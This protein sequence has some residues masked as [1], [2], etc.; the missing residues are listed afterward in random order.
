M[1][2]AASRTARLRLGASSSSCSAPPFHQAERRLA[3]AIA[4]LLLGSAPTNS[5]ISPAAPA[6]SCAAAKPGQPCRMQHLGPR[7]FVSELLHRPV[8][9]L[10]FIRRSDG[11]RLPSQLFFLARPD[12]LRNLPGCTRSFRRCSETRTDRPH[13]ASRTARLRLG[14]SSSSCSAPPF[15]QKAAAASCHCRPSPAPPKI[16]RQDVENG[17]LWLFLPKTARQSTAPGDVH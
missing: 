16:A 8:L 1:P 17:I 3:P 13:A 15:R 6:A 12:K 11:S 14:A 5:E 4:A 7:G 9:R 10:R 2:H